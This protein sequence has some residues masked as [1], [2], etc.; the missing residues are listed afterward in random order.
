[1]RSSLLALVAVLW[2]V[3]AAAMTLDAPLDNP[4][5][6]QQAQALFH[7]LRCMVCEGQSLA[8]SDATLAVQMRRQIREMV[9]QGKSSDDVLNYYR[10]RY[11]DRVVMTPPLATR[12]LGLWCAP[13]LL[14]LLGGIILWRRT[15]HDGGNHG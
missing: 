6:E 10:E 9:V 5:Q 2:C 14:M 15:R 4:V 7:N 13:L 3:S 11:S 12:T 1:M 8:E